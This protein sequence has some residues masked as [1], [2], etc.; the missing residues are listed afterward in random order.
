MPRYAYAVILVVGFLALW[1]L[2][3]PIRGWW[4]AT[5][6]SSAPAETPAEFEPGPP[7]TPDEKAA[8]I[9]TVRRALHEKLV[10]YKGRL[11][12]NSDLY[13]SFFFDV[14]YVPVPLVSVRCS[15]FSG[16]SLRGPGDAG[17]GTLLVGLDLLGLDAAS[18]DEEMQERI[19]SA[20]DGGEFMDAVCRVVI[21]ELEALSKGP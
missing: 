3:S 20:V 17:E 1:V 8:Y 4:Q 21:D 9:A 16:V 18:E 10:I 15:T 5:T 12:L 13:S 11:R 7:L 2:G 6:E 19:D 14:E